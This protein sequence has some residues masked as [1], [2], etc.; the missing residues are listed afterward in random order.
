VVDNTAVISGL[1]GQPYAL[2]ETGLVCLISVPN[3]RINIL[4]VDGDCH[5]LHERE[6]P[7]VC[8]ARINFV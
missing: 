5:D 8:F 3:L 7:L 4:S 6:I 1:V 2:T